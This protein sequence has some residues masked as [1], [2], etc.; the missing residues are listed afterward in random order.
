MIN[1]QAEYCSQCGANV[2]TTHTDGNQLTDDN[3]DFVVTE[4]SGHDPEFVGG[5]KSF[6]SPQDDLDLETTSDLVQD[7]ARAQSKNH[8]ANDEINHAAIDLS[9]IGDSDSPLPPPVDD[10]PIDSAPMNSRS[11]QPDP[12]T[13]AGPSGVA[14]NPD[15]PPP[16]GKAPASPRGSYLS[17]REKEEIIRKIGHHE[18]ISPP[19]ADVSSSLSEKQTPRNTPNENIGLPAPKIAKRGCGIAYFYRNFIQITGSQQL[20]KDDEV[21]IAD[22]HYKLKPK[23]L[24]PGFVIGASAALFVMT[25]IMIGSFLLSTGDTGN[26]EVIGIVLDQSGE[27]FIEGA[28]VRFPELGVAIKSTPDGFFR[29]GSIPAGSH[30]IEYR[31]NGKIIGEAFVTVASDKISTV[32]LEPDGK[33]RKSDTEMAAKTSPKTTVARAEP[34]VS[35][36][37]TKKNSKKSSRRKS[38][39]S[40]PSYAKL[41]LKANVEGARL[42]IDGNILGAGNMTYTRLKPGKHSYTV[43]ADG[44]NPATGTVNLKAGKTFSLEPTLEPMTLAQKEQTYSAEDFYFSGIN[45]IKDGNVETAIADFTKAVDKEPG[46]GEAYFERAKAYARLKDKES[47]HDDYLRAAEI[48]RFQKEINRAITSYNSAIEMNRKSIAAYLGRGD[49]YLAKGQ[50]IAALADYDEVCRI[51]KK[52]SAGHFGLGQARFQL[53]NYKKALKHF[54]QARSLDQENPVIYQ[55][56]MLSYLGMGKI[57]DVQKTFKKFSEIATESEMRRMASDKKFS[58]VM[59]VIE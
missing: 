41:K 5:T 3:L 11:T 13:S 35:Q 19:K 53:G 57:N 23:K 44:Y 59:A 38:T 1:P 29:S 43:E 15:A 9:P 54:K 4:T 24:R 58:A 39:K 26:G 20:H 2:N 31:I 21:V 17:E 6:D 55:Y 52:N 33:D 22:R 40:T 10:P 34:S 27:P 8:E 37:A 32:T 51:D 16:A 42:T 46:Y 56:M 48:F 14:S 28:V 25:L 47:A 7:E 12:Q 45:N 36:S 49:L 30:K 50:E 18:P